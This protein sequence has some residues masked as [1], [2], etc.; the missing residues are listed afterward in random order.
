MDIYGGWLQIMTPCY[1]VG[2]GHL[3]SYLQDSKDIT[4]ALL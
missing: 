4:D 1:P 3:S 2:E